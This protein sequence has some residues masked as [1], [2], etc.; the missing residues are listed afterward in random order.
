MPVTKKDYVHI[1]PDIEM[2][3]YKFE[4]TY[5]FTYLGSKV[6]CKN[7]ISAEIKKHVLSASRCFHGLRKLS[8]S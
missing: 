8:H 2:G 1:S 7:Y 6:I 4:T 3:P 5:S